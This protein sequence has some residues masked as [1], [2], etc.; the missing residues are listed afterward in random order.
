MCACSSQGPAPGQR[1]ACRRGWSTAN[2]WRRWQRPSGIGACPRRGALLQVAWGDTSRGPRTPWQRQAQSTPRQRRR[3]AWSA[4]TLTDPL[5]PR[6][7]DFGRRP[8]FFDPVSPGLWPCRT[9]WQVHRAGLCRAT[10][11][12]YS[13]AAEKP[14]CAWERQPWQRQG[15]CACAIGGTRRGQTS[16]GGMH[17]QCFC[18]LRHGPAAS[19]EQCWSLASGVM[20]ANRVHG[21]MRTQP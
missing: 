20:P 11:P 15:A 17:A 16:V 14:A 6:D 3:Q 2:T 1:P 18:R 21:R 7:G 4:P 10:P 19:N 9:H 8:C 13:A 5:E 12:G